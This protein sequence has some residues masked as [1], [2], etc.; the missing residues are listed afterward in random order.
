MWNIRG[1]GIAMRK[2]EL[3]ISGGKKEIMGIME[4][5]LCSNGLET[6]QTKWGMNGL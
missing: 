6:L 3:A 2:N 1:L 4:S 5:K